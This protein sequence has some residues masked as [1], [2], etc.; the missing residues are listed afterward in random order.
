[1]LL[2]SFEA[3]DLAPLD[4]VVLLTPYGAG[5]L[6]PP[7]AQSLYSTGQIAAIQAFATGSKFFVGDSSLW[8]DGDS[9]SDR[10][11]TFAD[12]QLL[13]DNVIDFITGGG[14]LLV[15]GEGEGSADIDNLN[16]VVAPWGV[17]FGSVSSEG[18]GGHVISSFVA[19]PVLAGITEIGVDSQRR[20]TVTGPALDLT[21]GGGADDSLA[22]LT[23]EPGTA[24][25]LGWAMIALSL[26]RRRRGA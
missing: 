4:A 21:P 19:H 14:G 15:I 16:E 20:L 3:A 25:L 7:P 13:L 12:N 26:R 5:G 17:S 18:S 11:I 10:P 23:P 1:V 6:V 8:M 22:V 24:A 2:S 9:G